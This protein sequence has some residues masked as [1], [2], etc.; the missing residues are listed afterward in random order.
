MAKSSQ[1]WS[2]LKAKLDETTLYL[3][4]RSGPTVFNIRD[5]NDELNRV[6]I[7]SPHSCTCT[8]TGGLCLHVLFVSLKVLR[9][10]DTNPYCKKTSWTDSEIDYVLSGACQPKIVNVKKRTIITKVADAESKGT[11]GFVSRQK[12]EDEEVDICPICQDGMNM[13]QALTWCRKG[14]GNNI[15]AKCMKMYT[16][17]K[18]GHQEKVVC[19]LCREDSW[20]PTPMV[21][22]NED[23]KGNEAAK[24]PCQLVHCISCTLPVKGDFYRCIECNLYPS[25]HGTSGDNAPF[26]PPSCLSPCV[27]LCARCVQHPGR[28]AKHHFLTSNTN[29][30]YSDF[31]WKAY[32]HPRARA[33]GTQEYLSCQ[34]FEND[35]QSRELTSNDYDIL[36]QLDRS[37]SSVEISVE[38]TLLSSLRTYSVS[39]AVSSNSATGA[40]KS[41]VAGAGRMTGA[42]AGRM[43][44]TGSVSL[45]AAT[46]SKVCWCE[47]RGE[48]DARGSDKYFVL[49]GCAHVAHK[50]CVQS[51]ISSACKGEPDGEQAPQPTHWKLD[52]IRCQHDDCSCHIFRSI[53]RKKRRGRR[54]SSAGGV[55]GVGG[56]GSSLAR[57]RSA[58]SLDAGAQGHA[59]TFVLAGIGIAGVNPSM[60]DHQSSYAIDSAA[61]ASEQHVMPRVAPLGR[62]RGKGGGPAG[63]GQN[64]HISFDDDDEGGAGST[65][66]TSYMAGKIDAIRQARSRR[67]LMVGGTVKHQVAGTATHTSTNSSIL[68][69]NVMSSS[70]VPKSD[71]SSSL[72]QCN[73][74]LRL[75]EHQSQIKNRV[76]T[77]IGSH[78]KK[79][80]EEGAGGAFPSSV[81]DDLSQIIAV[82][83]R[84]Q[85]KSSSSF[86]TRSAQTNLAEKEGAGQSA[87]GGGAQ[88][89]ISGDLQITSSKVSHPGG[90]VGITGGGR[91]GA[92]AAGVGVPPPVPTSR[93]IKANN[94]NVAKMAKLRRKQQMESSRDLCDN[95]VE[96]CLSVHQF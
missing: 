30:H 51:L 61:Q 15:H 3:V 13:A 94:L 74:K 31:V 5:E 7:G 11:E 24:R 14:C 19:P 65:K 79:E 28:H 56:T 69:L 49:P 42:G 9:V 76:I 12:L 34:L 59:G 38:E 27:D 85:T 40:T 18:S 4:H 47:G 41:H 16:Q 81:Q 8:K 72:I 88:E 92:S 36:L 58:S 73:D 39:A 21:L 17:Y 93:T 70:I 95:K 87:I 29:A 54:G 43:L 33:G 63:G 32:L 64:E 55:G 67:G 77:G 23:C 2:E 10:P 44:L 52:D 37:K 50:G 6:V 68:G 91:D 53:S 78:V 89:L 96:M 83:T 45:Q 22:L 75:H 48:G 66:P 80:G 71:M 84:L 1:D 35:L 46:A 90:A 86:R 20:G 57:D 26:P 60:G 82:Q 62:G 25:D